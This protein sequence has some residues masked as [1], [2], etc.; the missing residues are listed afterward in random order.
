MNMIDFSTND[1][2]DQFPHPCDVFPMPNGSKA[3]SETSFSLAS[4]YEAQKYGKQHR[5]LRG[6]CGIL[7][8]RD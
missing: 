4:C 8:P 7:Y 2:K 6:P 1:F 5:Q 3:Y